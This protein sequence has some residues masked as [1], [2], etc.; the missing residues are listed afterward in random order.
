MANPNQGDRLSQLPASQ[1]SAKELA[2]AQQNVAI[3][4][5]DHL[6][7][8]I[9]EQRPFLIFVGDDLMESLKPFW[10]TCQE[11]LQRIVNQYM[12]FRMNRPTGDVRL[13]KEPI[14]GKQIEVTLYKDDTLTLTELDRLVRWGVRQILDQDEHWELTNPAL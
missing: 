10:P 2:Q 5:P 14:T 1:A 11:E 8:W 9:A 6:K 13:E 3:K 4:D 7:R 12:A